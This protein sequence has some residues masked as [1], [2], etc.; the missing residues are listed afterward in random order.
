MTKITKEQANE[1]L[2]KRSQQVTEEDV[3]TVLNKQKE[4]EDKFKTGG[5]LGRYI[6]DLKLLFAIVKDYVNG[7]YREI[8]WYSIAAI[9]AALLY[10]LTP[11]DLIPDVI[12][13]IGLVDDAFVVAACLSMIENDLHKYKEWKLKQV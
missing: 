8:P 2:K 5:P 11:I 12:P 9:V 13:V 4:I 3:D 6:E 1:E 10:V 7:S